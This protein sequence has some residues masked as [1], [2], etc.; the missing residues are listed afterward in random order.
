MGKFISLLLV[1]LLL[2]GCVPGSD[3]SDISQSVVPEIPSSDETATDK[4]I[5]CEP[6][7][8]YQQGL[9]HPSI[10]E[11][12]PLP[13]AADAFLH[14][15]EGEFVLQY[16][17]LDALF[18]QGIQ[19][20]LKSE[21]RSRA[22]FDM[23]DTIRF[24]QNCQLPVI[25][26]LHIG[27]SLDTMQSLF[28]EPHF[29]DSDLGLYSYRFSD[30][31]LVCQGQENIAEISFIKYTVPPSHQSILQYYF[32]IDDDDFSALQH[33]MN[34][35]PDYLWYYPG[36]L[37]AQLLYANGLLFQYEEESSILVWNNYQGEIISPEPHSLQFIDEDFIFY[38]LCNYYQRENDLWEHPDAVSPDGS[39]IATGNHAARPVEGD[40][41]LLRWA[42]GSH[43]DVDLLTSHKQSD[44]L[45]LSNRYLVFNIYMNGPY[46]YDVAAGEMTSLLGAAGIE[47]PQSQYDITYSAGENG[48]LLID[49]TA[50]AY[51]FD[52]DGNIIFEPV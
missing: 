6:G 25:G 51:R 16:T 9:S 44:F 17:D 43:Q 36:G 2:A 34:Q 49:E 13:P 29:S 8:D 21:Y 38:Q 30:F 15:D 48:T 35:Y 50:I 42:D 45:W 5:Y 39:I 52:A 40:Q 46:L 28:G 20:R 47:A 32:D 19:Y 22:Y 27:D 24:G 1:V 7:V 41:V 18:E 37:G 4:V 23:L 12:P 33:I 26:S 31:Y 10:E 14:I 11:T 3:T